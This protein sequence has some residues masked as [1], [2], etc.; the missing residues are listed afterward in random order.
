M[1]VLSPI[2]LFSITYDKLYL[3][4]NNFK[5]TF[6]LKMFR[7]LN[8]SSFEEFKRELYVIKDV[9]TE[10]KLNNNIFKKE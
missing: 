5:D 2:A 10:L 9:V 8:E 6:E 4:I 7:E 3:G 1:N